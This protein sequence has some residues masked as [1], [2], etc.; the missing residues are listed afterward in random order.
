MNYRDQHSD[1]VR[2]LFNENGINADEYDNLITEIVQLIEDAKDEGKREGYE[3]GFS[4][5][6]GDLSGM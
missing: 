4:D 5:G 1:L 3:D 6:G 2:F